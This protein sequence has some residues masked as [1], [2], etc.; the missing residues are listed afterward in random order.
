MNNNHDLKKTK[1]KTFFTLKININYPFLGD[2]RLAVKWQY[3][4]VSVSSEEKEKLSDSS[5]IMHSATTC[6]FR[7]GKNG[8]KS[9]PPQLL[10]RMQRRTHSKLR[11][12]KKRKHALPITHYT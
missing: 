11:V 4:F 12:R 10:P 7:E 5:F 1:E 8:D 2:P 6:F 9:L 3:F